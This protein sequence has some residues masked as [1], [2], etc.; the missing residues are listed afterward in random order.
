MFTIKA[1][2][3]AFLA[4]VILAGGVTYLVMKP[5]SDLNP[6]NDLMCAPALSPTPTPA[7]MAAHKAREHA[8]LAPT[9]GGDR[10]AAESLP[11]PPANTDSSKGN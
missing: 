2:V 9:T 1:L 3:G 5:A 4:G 11:L 6:N 10:P 7:D 8:I